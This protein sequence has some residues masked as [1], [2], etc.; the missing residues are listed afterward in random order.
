[1][2]PILVGKSKKALCY[3]SDP[4]ISYMSLDEFEGKL[5]KPASDSMYYIDADSCPKKKFRD[6]FAILSKT[7]ACAWAVLD[8][9]ATIADPGELFLG[10]AADYLSAAVLDSGIGGERIAK[11][12]RF[13]LGEKPEEKQKADAFPGW[14][15]LVKGNEYPFVFLYVDLP[16]AES[17]KKTLGE[18]RFTRLKEDF[19]KGIGYELQAADGRVWMSDGQSLLALFPVEKTSLAVGISLQLILGNALFSYEKLGLRIP[20]RLRFAMHTGTTIWQKPGQT[21]NV[22]SSD[23]NFIYHLGR[24]FAESGALYVSEKTVAAVSDAIR[25]LLKEQ[26]SFEGIAVSRSRYFLTGKKQT[27]ASA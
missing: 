21:G 23:V 10:G 5:E 16:D 27:H 24:K 2:K 8:H 22:I 12:A 9:G 14:D 15:N 20:G 26:G 19:V 11:A 25:P 13:F 4:G 17:I 18:Q 1:M 6:L 3:F 7:D